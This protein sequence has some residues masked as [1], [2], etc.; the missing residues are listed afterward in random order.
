MSRQEGGREVYWRTR[1]L[2]VAYLVV[3]FRPTATAAS[4]HMHAAAAK[5]RKR[6]M[7]EHA[8][9]LERTGEG[10]EGNG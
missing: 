6:W 3:Y 5:R 9:T 1:V 10:G 4:A 8:D 2:F 7:L